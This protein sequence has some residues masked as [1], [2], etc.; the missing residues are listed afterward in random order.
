MIEEREN[1]LNREIIEKDSLPRLDLIEEKDFDS[2]RLSERRLQ[3]WSACV[4][5]EMGD[6]TRWIQSLESGIIRRDQRIEKLEI[7]TRELEEK[8]ESTTNDYRKR[9]AQLQYELIGIRTSKAWKLAKL[10]ERFSIIVS[11]SKLLYWTATGKLATKLREE[12]IY[13]ELANSGLFDPEYYLMMNPDVAAA[14]ADPLKHYIDNY[15]Q[16]RNPNQCF[17][18]LSYLQSHPDIDINPL[19]HYYRVQNPRGEK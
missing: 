5:Q 11:W 13:T 14:G 8:L 1:P 19:L 12:K 6:K 4:L 16:G 9:L 17:D 10:F 3:E 2:T 15:L 18:T 7:R